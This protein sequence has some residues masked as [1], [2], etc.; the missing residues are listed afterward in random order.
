M[1]RIWKIIITVVAILVLAVIGTGWYLSVHWKRILDKELRQYVQEGSD[2]LYTLAYGRLDL[3]L[4]NGNLTIHNAALIPDSAVYQRLV[5]QQKAPGALIN[6]KMSRLQISRLKLWRYFLDK[7]VDAGAFTIIDPELIIVSD[8]RSVD[9]TTHQRSFYEVVNKNI[10]HFS[11]S[12]L[13]L[14]KIKLIYTQIGKDSS[15][16]ITK[17]EDLDIIIR[18][19]QIDSVS[20][21]DPARFLYARSFDINLEKWDHRTPDSLY[22]LH[23]KKISYHAAERAMDIGEIELKP[24]YNRA[25]FDKQIKTQKDMFQLVFRNI[26]LKGIPR[27]YQLKQGVYI[28]RGSI[29]GGELNVYR[30]RSLPL[31][32][33]DKYGQFPNQLLAKLKLPLQIDTLTASGV[34][35]SYTEKNP[36]NGETGKIQFLRAGGTF[37]H[38]TNVDSLVAKNKH[39]TAD[40]HAILMKSGKLRASF[41]FILGDASGA[42]GVSGQLNNMDGKEFNPVTKP[43]GMVEIRSAQIK[44]L[45]F[46]FRGNE[47]SA[48]GTLKF[49]YSNLKISMLKEE[50]DP[51]GNQRKGL[52]SLL[53]NLMVI[54]NENPSPGEAVRIVKPRFQRDPKKSFFNLVWKTIFTGVKET[55]GTDMLAAMEAR[56]K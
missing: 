3:N 1:K 30:N 54:K 45:E 22:W 26:N 46:N 16:V 8:Q 28:Q 9:T 10:N 33:G 6:A 19:L 44:E 7:D 24:R 39:C 29:N 23:V 32:P 35:V 47:K 18:G 38:I 11:I 14:N 21:N 15:K 36:K 40:L 43:L 5:A 4:L 27:L 52:A 20:Q 48:S 53:A 17:L 2:S 13:T 41:D 12:R 49:L 25:D 51:N 56:N 42:F 34:D 50:K 31:P 55:V 37:R